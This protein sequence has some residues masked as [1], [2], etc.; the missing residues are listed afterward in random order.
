MAQRQ[1][2]SDDTSQWTYGFGNGS[3][4]ALS[5]SA[6]TTEAPIDSAC[7]GTA[8]QTS[9]SATNA[10]FAVGQVILIHQTRHA[11]NAGLWELNKIASYSAGTITLNEPLINTYAALA[12]VRVLKQYSSVTIDSG[13]TYTAKAWDG[14]V[15]GIIGWLCSGTTAITGNVLA[16]GK[17]Y[18]GGNYNAGDGYQ[19]ESQISAGSAASAANGMGGGGGG[20]GAS[21]AAGGGGGGGNAA[22]GTNGM[23]VPPGIG[24][25]IGGIAALTTLL[26]GGAGG[27]GGYRNGSSGHAG[28]GGN[29]GGI[30]F[31][32]STTLTM[33]G[34]ATIINGGIAGGN[35]TDSGSYNGGGGGGAGG[36]TL[37]KAMN[38][39][40]G[41]VL[42]TCA[43]GAGGLGRSGSNDGGPGSVGRIHLDYL[44]STTGTTTPTLD[45]THDLTLDYR[46]GG[47][48]LLNML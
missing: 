11:T 37:V 8:T 1:F 46:Y 40:L 12:Q 28:A 39:T 17:G 33:I 44:V 7:T 42:I 41:T 19:G 25:S 36:A 21:D 10:N 16:T 20:Y 43:A 4:G 14:T 38:A 27:A 22:A 35:N 18:R 15:G 30:I 23:D 24:G 34:S 13:K 32:V 2:R 48:F 3:D 26:F 31:I 29:S 9:L 6:D 5:I 45:S 47:G